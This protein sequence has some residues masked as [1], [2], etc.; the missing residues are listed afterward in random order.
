VL[1]KEQKSSDSNEIMFFQNK[2]YKALEVVG[3]G[4]ST[5]HALLFCTLWGKAACSIQVMRA[6]K[7]QKEVDKP[8]FFAAGIGTMLM[9]T[10]WEV[11]GGR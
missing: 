2:Q 11:C 9:C 3:T 6:S 8:G 1:Y 4:K 10:S 5:V 7:L